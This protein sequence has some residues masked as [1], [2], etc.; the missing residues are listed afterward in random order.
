MRERARRLPRP[1]FDAI[2]GGA[3][4]ELTLRANRAAYDRVWF[5][6]R[7]LA[8]GSSRDLST[9]VF[10]DKIAMP[11]L[12]APCGMARMVHSGGELAVARAAGRARTVYAVSGVSSYSLEEISARGRRATLVSAL[13]RLRPCLD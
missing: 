3:G 7:A 12:L 11:L 1:I 13:P 2:D 10:G 9:T 5:R 6:P 4:D 8:G